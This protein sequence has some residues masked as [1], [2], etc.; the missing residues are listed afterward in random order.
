MNHTTEECY[1]KHGYPPWYKNKEVSR[2]KDLTM[3]KMEVL[4]KSTTSTLILKLKDMLIR[5]SRKTLLQ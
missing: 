3:A 5:L 4:N 2:K 1:S